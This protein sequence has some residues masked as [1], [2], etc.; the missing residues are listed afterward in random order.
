MNEFIRVTSNAILKVCIGAAVMGVVEAARNYY[1]GEE[2][3][4]P[5]IDNGGE[6]IGTIFSSHGRKTDG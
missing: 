6:D 4:R 5:S 2:R 3:A 1:A